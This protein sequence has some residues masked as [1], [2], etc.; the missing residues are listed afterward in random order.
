MNKAAE[1]AVKQ[2]SE[3]IFS[4]IIEPMVIARTAVKAK[5]A[6]VTRYN[7][8]EGRGQSNGQKSVRMVGK[9]PVATERSQSIG[10]A[11]LSKGGC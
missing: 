10:D 3:Q 2:Q 9:P 8:E 1:N 4:R 11:F 7:A 5:S 6:N